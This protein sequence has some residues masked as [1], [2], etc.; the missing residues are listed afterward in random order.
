VTCLA[1]AVRLVSA[2]K[3]PEDVRAGEALERDLIF[4]GTVGIIDPPR[5]RVERSIQAARRAD[6]QRAPVGVLQ[7]YFFAARTKRYS[8]S[9]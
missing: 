7:R 4:V 8:P 6:I 1:Y 5:P 3:P 9:P 2:I